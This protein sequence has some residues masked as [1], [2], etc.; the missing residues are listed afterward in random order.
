[1]YVISNMFFVRDL[2]PHL[3]HR[4]ISITQNVHFDMTTKKSENHFAFSIY[5]NINHFSL[6]TIAAFN[7]A[8]AT[9][10]FPTFAFA[11]IITNL[12]LLLTSSTSNIS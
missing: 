10:L 2:L 1:M 5:E 7:S 4:D 9:T 12:L 3:W 8:S 6:S 11:L